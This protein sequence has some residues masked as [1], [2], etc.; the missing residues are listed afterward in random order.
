MSAVMPSSF[1]FIQT[2]ALVISL[3]FL[4][5]AAAL[6][7]PPLALGSLLDKTSSLRYIACVMALTLAQS[8]RERK[9]QLVA[10]KHV[11]GDLARLARVSYSMAYK[12]MNGKR[13]SQKCQ[14]A[15]DVLTNGGR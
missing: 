8:T 5:T 6:E 15:F 9:R 14:R 12:W 3:S 4:A 2:L 1:G 11:Y 13:K 7:S 10:S